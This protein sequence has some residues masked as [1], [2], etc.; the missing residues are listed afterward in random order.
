MKR[1][2]QLWQLRM[3]QYFLIA[4]FTVSGTALAWIG[5]LI[6]HVDRRIGWLLVIAG[7][8]TLVMAYGESRT[9]Y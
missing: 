3:D 5:G 7:L 2:H 1:K 6:V 9:R 8:L 4:L